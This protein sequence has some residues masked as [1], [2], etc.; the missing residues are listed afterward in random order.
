MTSITPITF[1]STYGT[2]DAKINATSTR[3]LS[4]SASI[5]STPFTNGRRNVILKNKLNPKVKAMAKELYFN[6]DG[7]A[8]KKL[9]VSICLFRRKLV[10]VIWMVDICLFVSFVGWRQ[11]ACGFSRGYSWSKR[12]QCSS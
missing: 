2:L 8:I 5:S 12:A 11:Q 10:L 3:S 4:S 7:S 6:K 9:Q 1:I